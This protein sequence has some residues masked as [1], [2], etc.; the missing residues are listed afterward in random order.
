MKMKKATMSKLKKMLELI[1]C[2]LP[3]ENEAKED[4]NE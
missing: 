4:D 2:I 1:I 3:P